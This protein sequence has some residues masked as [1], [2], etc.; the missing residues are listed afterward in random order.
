MLKRISKYLVLEQLCNVTSG[1]TRVKAKGL[2][3][4]NPFTQWVVQQATYVRLQYDLYAYTGSEKHSCS[5]SKSITETVPAPAFGKW[6]AKKLT[7]QH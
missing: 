3:G 7:P 4:R 6:I 1:G 2:K 5:H